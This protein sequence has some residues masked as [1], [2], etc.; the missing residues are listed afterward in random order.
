[1][2]M[3]MILID[4]QFPTLSQNMVLFELQ[5]I[6]YFNNSADIFYETNKKE[7]IVCV[8]ESK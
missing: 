8:I 3:M 6:D 2:L 7:K 4:A 5:F 1:M